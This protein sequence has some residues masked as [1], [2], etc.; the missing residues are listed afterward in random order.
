MAKKVTIQE[1]WNIDRIKAISFYK[2]CNKGSVQISDYYAQ[3]LID[4]LSDGSL[5]SNE[6]DIVMNYSFMC[7]LLSNQNLP[8]LE[9]LTR[10]LYES[11]GGILS[12]KSLKNFEDSFRDVQESKISIDEEEYAIYESKFR[13]FN[14][15]TATHEDIIEHLDAGFFKHS[16]L[17]IKGSVD[18]IC[19]II[20]IPETK[21]LILEN[22]N[23]EDISEI[24]IKCIEEDDFTTIE[25][26]YL[27]NNKLSEIS[28]FLTEGIR[29]LDLSYNNFQMF[30][31]ENLPLS[32]R[33]LNLSFNPNLSNF[34]LRNITYLEYLDLSNTNISTLEH[35]PKVVSTLILNDCRNLKNVVLKLSFVN[36]F[37]SNLSFNLHLNKSNV[38]VLLGTGN[39]ITVYNTNS[40]IFSSKNVNLNNILR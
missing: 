24:E 26:L 7:R 30:T 15:G 20:I 4:S 8:H 39:T 17:T 16:K 2:N 36:F 33:H 28:K 6:T 27:N 11:E 37:H 3:M 12:V 14:Y 1:I 25:S 32:L 9:R 31:S 23:L 19:E 29:Q 13:Q 22:N 21:T 40:Q 18:Y 35:I 10:S 34:N 38:D 5:S